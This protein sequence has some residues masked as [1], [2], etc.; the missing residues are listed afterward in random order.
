L[1]GPGRADLTNEFGLD[2]TVPGLH[3]RRYSDAAT[4]RT[5]AEGVF[6]PKSIPTALGV[7]SLSVVNWAAT[8]PTHAPDLLGRY[9]CPR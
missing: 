3:S 4:M 1:P 9:V 8:Y 5:G 6:N 7:R 2:M